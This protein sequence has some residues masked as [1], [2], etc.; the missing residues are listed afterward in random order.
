MSLPYSAI[1][2]TIMLP[3]DGVISAA[4]TGKGK[5]KAKRTADAISISLCLKDGARS[6]AD[7]H[8]FQQDEGEDGE[9]RRKIARTDR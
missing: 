1:F 3:C 8:G 7:N 5:G 4:P 9:E 6:T 2:P